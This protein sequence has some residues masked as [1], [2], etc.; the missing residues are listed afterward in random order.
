MN[1]IGCDYSLNKPAITVFSNN[2]YYFYSWP[3]NISEKDI[4]KIKNNG[5]HI[6]TRKEERPKKI[7]S[8]DKVRFDIINSNNLA[9]L[10]INDIK[11]YI[12]EKTIFIFEG[13]SFGSYGNMALQLTSWRYILV[14]KLSLIM[15]LKNIYSYSPLTLKATAG[16]SKKGTKKGDMIESFIKNGPN[17]E[18]RQSLIDKK[19]F[20]GGG[21]NWI[22]IVDDLV[23]SYFCIET[24][25][26]KEDL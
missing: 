7:S 21:K 14:Y 18:F 6:T 19:L 13:S 8:S 20:N 17:T 23:D 5:V 24:F 3:Y 22:P 11:E 4:E 15:P 1:I 10:I 16:C 2:Q 26:L 9:D 12:N 25:K